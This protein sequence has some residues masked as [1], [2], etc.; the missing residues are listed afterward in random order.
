[1]LHVELIGNEAEDTMQAN[2]LPFYT[3]GSK[4]F[5][6]EVGHVANQIKG[7]DLKNIMQV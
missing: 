3:P 7:K 4:Q 1:M 6:S 2:I 5:F